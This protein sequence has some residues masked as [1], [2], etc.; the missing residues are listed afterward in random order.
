MVLADVELAGAKERPWGL[1]RTGIVRVNAGRE[2]LPIFAG[3]HAQL[4][5]LLAQG[6]VASFPSPASIAEPV[7]IR[8]EDG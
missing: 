5:L 8:W 4:S 3:E 6:A 2:P 7:G 1:T